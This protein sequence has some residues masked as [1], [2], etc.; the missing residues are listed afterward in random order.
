MKKIIFWTVCLLSAWN[1]KGQQKPHYSQYVL[2]QYILNPALSGIENYTDVKLSHRHQWVGIED[3]PVTTYITAHMP[4]GKSDF[5]T[6]STSYAMKGENPRGSSYWE[7]YTASE[8]HHGIGVQVINDRTGPITHLNAYLTYAYHLGLSAKTNLSAGFGVG[9]KRLG[10]NSNKLNFGTPVD[11]AVANSGIINKTTPDI[12]AGLYLYS[13]SFFLGL[14]AQQILP[15]KLDFSGSTVRTQDSRLV[16]HFFGTAG[17]RLL[18]TEDINM[19]PSVMVKYLSNLPTQF[20]INTKFQYQDIA[21]LGAGY[22]LNDGYMGMVGLN[23]N[24]TFNLSYS[25][26]YTTSRLNTYSK[27]T[28][29]ILIGFVLGNTYGDTCPR[30]VW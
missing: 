14:S 24:N 5:K 19:I 28:H 10:L 9:L 25:Y 1:V 22:R 21:W 27:G 11:P 30:N 23:V 16:P 4:L 6:T 15:S 12:N 13:S 20:D 8:P 26:D 3:A 18:V 17:V 7:N 29:E 2:N